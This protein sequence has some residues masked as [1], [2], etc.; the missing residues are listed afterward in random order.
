MVER[1]RPVSGAE[2]SP[3]ACKESVTEITERAEVPVVEKTARVGEEVVVR[4]DENVRDETVRDTVRRQDVEV[5][6]DGDSSL[7]ATPTNK[8]ANEKRA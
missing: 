6:R 5:T 3:D 7:A 8:L 2:P 4:T 1:R